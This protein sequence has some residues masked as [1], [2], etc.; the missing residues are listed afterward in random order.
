MN[1]R[2][3]SIISAIALTNGCALDPQFNLQELQQNTPDKS[4]AAKFRLSSAIVYVQRST[5][6]DKDQK[7]EISK[8]TSSAINAPAGPLFSLSGR[9][10]FF[11]KTTI[12]PKTT[13]KK[14]LQSISVE[15]E[16]KLEDRIK[17][18][19]ALTKQAAKLFF[20]GPLLSA[21]ID[22][23]PANEEEILQ[24]FPE[25]WALDLRSR[26]NQEGQWIDISSGRTTSEKWQAKF[27]LGPRSSTSFSL[28]ASEASALASKGILVY[29]SCQDLT[30]ELR[31]VQVNVA[32]AV[33]DVAYRLTDQEVVPNWQYVETIKFPAKGAVA[34]D[35]CSANVTKSNTVER[36]ILTVLNT[37]L[38]EVEA[39]A[40]A[41]ENKEVKK[42][43]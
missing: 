43:K 15:T 32:G 17:S 36:D 7:K 14:L 16:D 40:K 10:G 5:K 42:D 3:I 38:S 26:G 34:F 31:Y 27:N 18:A 2:L 28:D 39:V 13:K 35:G 20:A 21:G 11:R 37:T 24:T 4:G 29:S 12:L 19:S 22:W 33:T 6:Y 41:F 25:K 1:N 30:L 8:L 23:P 9:D